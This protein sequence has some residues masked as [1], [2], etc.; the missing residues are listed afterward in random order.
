M[1]V[2]HQSE[3]KAQPFG[4]FTGQATSTKAHW[5][6]LKN[7]KP[8]IMGHRATFSFSLSSSREWFASPE[9]L[10]P[11]VPALGISS[12][13][14]HACQFHF[15]VI[16]IERVIQN[17]CI[18]SVVE[19][20]DV[21]LRYCKWAA[22]V[23]LSSKQ[24]WRSLSA[25]WAACKSSQAQW[26]V[27][28]LP[29]LCSEL[30]DENARQQQCDISSFTSHKAKESQIWLPLWF[31]EIRTFHLQNTNPISKQPNPI[32]HG[33]LSVVWVEK[34]FLYPSHK[35]CSAGGSEN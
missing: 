25:F 33:S 27:Y 14:L 29:H 2:L 1:S 9:I 19:G 16:F 30:S 26:M 4:G 7:Q 15:S 8:L 31:A 10:Q 18:C 35:L 6:G 12:F 34:P 28:Y 3:G 20:T 5:W 21:S 24:L 11:S 32:R 23:P 22:A 17:E 13:T